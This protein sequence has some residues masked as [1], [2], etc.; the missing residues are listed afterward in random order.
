MN[1]CF[2]KTVM[3]QLTPFSVAAYL[4]LRHVV[5][6]LIVIKNANI[7]YKLITGFM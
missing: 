7:Y 3:K 1:L 5:T 4:V 6:L 2:S